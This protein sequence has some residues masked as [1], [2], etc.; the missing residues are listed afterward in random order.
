[1]GVK[2]IEKGGMK[3]KTLRIVEK[4]EK[5]TQEKPAKALSHGI[6]KNGFETFPSGHLQNQIRKIDPGDN[7]QLQR[8]QKRG[9]TSISFGIPSL[10]STLNSAIPT[11]TQFKDLR[12][13]GPSP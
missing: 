9:L 10:G 5:V 3:M 13:R 6:V 11:P 2:E 1:M 7:G 4:M 8:P 12:R